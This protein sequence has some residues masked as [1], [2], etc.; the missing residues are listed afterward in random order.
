MIWPIGSVGR[1][2]LAPLLICAGAVSADAQSLRPAAPVSKGGELVGRVTASADGVPLG[3]AVIAIE[4]TGRLTTTTRNGEYRLVGVPLGTQTVRVR[5]LGFRSVLRPIQV[6]GRVVADFTLDTVPAELDEPVQAYSAIGTVP[7]HAVPGVARVLT[8]DEL[9]ARGLVTI[10]DA[11]RTLGVSRLADD[12]L[13]HSGHLGIRGA[14][15]T[16]SGPPVLVL[17]DGI[18]VASEYAIRLVDLGGIERIEVLHGPQ[19]SIV[20]GPLAQGGVVQ[21][22]SRASAFAPRLAPQLEVRA[23]LGYIETEGVPGSGAPTVES[24]VALAG[25]GPDFTY[26]FGAGYRWRGDWI[27]NGSESGPVLFG[28]FRIR[29][30]SLT[31]AGALRYLSRGFEWTYNPAFEQIAP[32]VFAARSRVDEADVAREQQYAVRAAYAP[33]P[34]W[35][36]EI[37]LGFA[38]VGF[39]YYSRRPRDT[40]GMQYLYNGMVSRP[41]AAYRTGWTGPLGRWGSSSL[42]FGA[43]YAATTSPGSYWTGV[44]SPR[45]G[46][47]PND[48]TVTTYAYFGSLDHEALFAQGILRPGPHLSVTAGLRT[49]RQK[50][51]G[52]PIDRQWSAHAGVTYTRSF[53]ATVVRARASYGAVPTPARYDALEQQI[54]GQLATRANRRIRPERLSVGAVG[55]EFHFNR[56]ASLIASHFRRTA[57]DRLD[58]VVVDPD[59]AGLTLGEY[60]NLGEVDDIGWDLEVRLALGHLRLLGRYESLRSRVRRLAPDFTGPI[61]VGDSPLDVPRH[62]ASLSALLALPRTSLLLTA[63]A[64]GPRLNYDFGRLFADA[65][66][67]AWQPALSR[68]LYLREYPGFVV[69]GLSAVRQLTGRI[70]AFLSVRDLFARG[71]IELTNYTVSESRVS[72]AGLRLRP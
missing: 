32:S 26:R 18:E 59:S 45:S 10:E 66:N 11:A 47:L 4:G 24:H 67:G 17:L 38:S 9:D 49:D 36:H 72:Q 35:V 65:E 14:N 48:S 37:V 70:Q 64:V 46:Y 6:S 39:D 41:S 33:R 31:V 42:V 40:V 69:F 56:R 12:R 22:T 13:D 5:C 51:A 58:F 29:Q 52:A 30:G 50:A 63:C 34:D 19:A 2:S 20:Y 44:G 23:A 68:E 54:Y 28:G 7:A 61:R 71:P 3:G 21:L 25:G 57:Q 53:G 16:G 62:A 43:E 27:P 8:A 60:Q 1:W 15:P 55:L